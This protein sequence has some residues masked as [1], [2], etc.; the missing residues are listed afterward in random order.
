MRSLGL[1]VVGGKRA[2]GSVEREALKIQEPDELPDAEVVALSVT[3]R[4]ADPQDCWLAGVDRLRRIGARARGK[5]DS[6]KQ[7]NAAT[8]Q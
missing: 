7:K 1:Q 5:N 2:I 8:R 4:Y 6:R 3:F